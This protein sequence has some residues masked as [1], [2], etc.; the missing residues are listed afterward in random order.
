M[1]AAYILISVGA[2]D[3]LEVMDQLR[4][5]PA[6][7]HAHILLGPTDAIAFVECEDHHRLRETILEIRSIK[8]VTDTDTRYVYS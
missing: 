1:V 5:L 6:V 3:P 2:G 7:K 8:G 4:M